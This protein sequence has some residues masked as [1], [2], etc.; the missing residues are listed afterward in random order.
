M[1]YKG[2][3]FPRLNPKHSKNDN[4]TGRTFTFLTVGEQLGLTDRGAIVWDCI[5]ICGN[6]VPCVTG[7]LFR[8]SPKACSKEC[9]RKHSDE[10]AWN[11]HLA[12]EQRRLKRQTGECILCTQPKCQG[13]SYCLQHENLRLRQ[14]RQT[15]RVQALT[16][17]GDTCIYHNSECRGP[18]EIDH[19]YND[20]FIV[21][22]R[23]Q[24]TSSGKLKRSHKNTKTLR[25]I[26][27]HPEEA[28]HRLQPLCRFHNQQKQND[29]EAAFVASPEYQQH[30]KV[31]LQL[32][33]DF[34]TTYRSERFSKAA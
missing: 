17:I 32:R 29:F 23:W 21:E 5:C 10:T 33:V 27:A 13:S 22:N 11:E 9:F 25:W 18:I 7:G 8:G 16:I 20:G 12:R 26:I 6:H 2:Q 3:I 15:L 4:L 34:G 1:I 28:K 19:I 31:L 30:R 14:R 24:R